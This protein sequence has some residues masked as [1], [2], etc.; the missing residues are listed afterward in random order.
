M[1]RLS[2]LGPEARAQVERD[3]GIPPTKKPRP[4]DKSLEDALLFQLRALKVPEPVREYRFHPVRRWRFDFSWLDEKLAVE[5]DGGTWNNGGHNRGKQI[6]S[7]CEKQNTAVE[8]G[9]KLLRVTGDM[10]HDG[11]AAALIERLFNGR[12]A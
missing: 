3:Y 5:V 8:A 7:D 6:E 1:V 12:K 10:V 4:V 9:W 2:D 11:R